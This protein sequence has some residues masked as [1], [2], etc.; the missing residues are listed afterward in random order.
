MKYQFNNDYSE[1]AH[2]Q[3]LA[4]L[5]AVGYSQFEGYGLDEYCLKAIDLIR[6][7]TAMPTADVHFASG[8]TH[9][10][11]IV[12]AASLRP[13]EAVIATTLGHINTHETGAIEATGHKICPV[14]EKDGKLT[15]GDIQAIVDY[16]E[17][18]HMV[19]PRAVYISQSTELGSVYNRAELT[20]LHECCKAN[21]LY[22][23]ADGARLGAAINSQWCDLSYA[24]FANLVDAFYI[25]GTKNGA[26]YGEAIVIINDEIK[27]AFRYY[28]KQHGALLAKSAGM[29]IQFTALFT[30]GLYDD[31]ARHA[32]SMGARL[33]AGITGLG[34]ELLSPIQTNQVF[35][36]LPA[37]IVEQLHK[38]Y[39]FHD[40]ES[41]GETA[42]IR[43]VAS[44]ATKEEKIDQFLE[45]LAAL[46]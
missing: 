45:D 42:A 22:L 13:F 31:L 30:E 21:G 17:G 3:V 26:I 36:I 41:Y 28:L 37:S 27:P 15:A 7:K 44:W 4:A 6:E 35:P 39:G 11:L 34:Y 14:A 40:W 10:N 25:G 18:E 5:S 46:S 38:I 33:A 43:L 20:A 29:G 12:L 23:Y 2:P 32:N 24:D 19:K 1:L 9:A 16:H 8:G